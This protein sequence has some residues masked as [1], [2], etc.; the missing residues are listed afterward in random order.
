MT[1]KGKLWFKEDESNKENEVTPLPKKHP[2]NMF[3][4]ELWNKI[5]DQLTAARGSTDG[6]I[7]SIQSKYKKQGSVDYLRRTKLFQG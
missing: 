4:A 6:L 3:V 5:N 2:R 1:L 7:T